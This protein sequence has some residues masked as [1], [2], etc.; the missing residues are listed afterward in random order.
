M[1]NRCSQCVKAFPDV[2]GLLQHCSETGHQP[3]FNEKGNETRE[4]EPAVFISF[5][6]MVLSRALSERLAKW[7]REYIDPTKSTEPVDRRGKS[8]GVTLF[9]AYTAEFSLCKPKTAGPS[10]AH[11]ALT[12][13]LRAKLL[14]SQSL[15]DA[16]YDGKN[17]NNYQ[18]TRQEQDRARRQWIGETVIYKIDK[19]TYSVVDLVR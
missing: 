4:A 18:L 8:L 6:N 11:L 16:L 19:K 9:E 7:G 10:K 13:D 14:R 3:V 17:V 12:V 1:D 2:R 5:V 15:L